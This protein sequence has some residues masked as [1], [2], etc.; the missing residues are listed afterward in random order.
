MELDWSP[1]PSSFRVLAT[2]VG[3]SLLGLGCDTGAS[4]SASQ[5][6]L[7]TANCTIPTSRINSGCAGGA[8]CI[9]AINDIAPGDDRLRDGRPDGLRA[10]DR[11]IGLLFGEQA[12]AVPHKILWTHE[13]VN[14]D[15]WAGHTF[16]ITY[17]PLTGTSIAFDLSAIDGAEFGVSG[18]LFNNNLVMYDRGAEE[19]SLWPQ[20]SKQATCGANVG[21]SLSTLP[22]IE[23]EWEQ[24]R[25]LHPDTQVLDDGNGFNREDPYGDYDEDLSS[26]PLFDMPVDDRRLPKERVLG[27]PAGEDGG[28]ALPFAELNGVGDSVNVV[29]VPVGGTEKTVFWNREA[30]TAMAFETSTAFSV[31][32]GQIVDAETGSVWS[33]EGRALEGTRAGER[34][35]VDREA[36]VGFWFAWAAFQPETEIWEQS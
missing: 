35:P 36:Y 6:D 2:L 11:V 31:Q 32:D 26:P 20:M 21:T 19:P 13:I 34:L 25:E 18:L 17:C 8:D 4:T 15:E 29:T 3:L 27:I 12:L 30:R 9:P 22:V 28:L 1:S 24:W 10:D 23:M 33:V 16:S 5:P 7:N 14:V